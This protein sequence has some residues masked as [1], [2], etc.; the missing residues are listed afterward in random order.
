[1]DKVWIINFNEKIEIYKY[2]GCLYDNID[3]EIV[4]GSAF[5]FNRVRFLWLMLVFES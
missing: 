2:W 1:M 3:N 5:C 4:D